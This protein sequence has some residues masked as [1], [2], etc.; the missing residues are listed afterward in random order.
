VIKV[1][2]CGEVEAFSKI[3]AVSPVPV[4]AAGGPQQNTLEEAVNMMAAVVESGA[5]GATIGRNIWGFPD[6]LAAMNAFKAVIHDR[7][8]PDEALRFAGV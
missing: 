6:I 7:K 8:T 1:P 2:Y 3:V 4:V 5:R